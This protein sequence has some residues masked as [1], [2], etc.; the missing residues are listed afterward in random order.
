VRVS[1]RYAAEKSLAFGLRPVGALTLA[2]LCFIF[3]E[4]KINDQSAV[5]NDKIDIK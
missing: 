3:S 1:N 4:S 2:G 5:V